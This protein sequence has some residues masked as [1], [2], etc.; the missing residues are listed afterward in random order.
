MDKFLA[1]LAVSPVATALKVGV[2]ASLGY[3]LANPDILG[4]PPVVA[5]GVVAALPVLINWFNPADDRYGN[6]S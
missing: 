4:V 2:A 1:W 5:V 6:G 3:V